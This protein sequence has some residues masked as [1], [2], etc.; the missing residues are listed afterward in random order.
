ML[1][2]WVAGGC[3]DVTDIRTQRV[4]AQRREY[5]YAKDVVFKVAKETLI[6]LGFALND[7]SYSEGFISGMTP[8]EGI[9]GFKSGEIVGI[10]ISGSGPFSVVEV[11]WLR[12]SIFDPAARNWTLQIFKAIDERL[13]AINSK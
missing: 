11:A 6:S 8:S 5:K 10:W 4:K 7:I 3:R 13:S 9:L 1:I 2:Y 12:R